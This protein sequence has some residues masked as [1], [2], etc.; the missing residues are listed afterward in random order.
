MSF[1]LPPTI[2]RSI[3]S[4]PFLLLRPQAH[5]KRPQDH[6][7]CQYSRVLRTTHDVSFA[8]DSGGLIC[9]KETVSDLK[10]LDLRPSSS[11]P[12]ALKTSSRPQEARVVDLARWE[13]SVCRAEQRDGCAR[14]LAPCKPLYSYALSMLMQLLQEGSSGRGAQGV[15]CRGGGRDVH[16]RGGLKRWPPLRTINPRW[17][18]SRMAWAEWNRVGLL[19]R[20][21]ALVAICQVSP[22]RRHCVL[23]ILPL[24]QR[25]KHK[26]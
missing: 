4:L 7:A 5:L 16:G 12:Q 15:P 1:L 10:T 20:A 22:P 6:A 18:D 8:A 25:L 26:H 9:S 14:V 2:L 19:W 11:R 21:R 23:P 13:L 24:A 3:S 17:K